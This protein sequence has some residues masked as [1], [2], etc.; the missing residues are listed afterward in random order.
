MW[1]AP[2]PRN[3]RPD[4]IRLVAVVLR[5]R[6]FMKIGRGGH[7]LVQRPGREAEEDAPTLVGSWSGLIS[8]MGFETEQPKDESGLRQVPVLA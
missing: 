6:D 4:R 8:A 2:V 7:L 1:C 5:E 3:I